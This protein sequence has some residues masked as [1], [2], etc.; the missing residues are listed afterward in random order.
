MNVAMKLFVKIILILIIAVNLAVYPNQACAA[1]YHYCLCCKNTICKHDI[2]CDGSDQSLGHIAK[3]GHCSFLQC[4]DCKQKENTQENV[5]LTDPST[6]SKKKIALA[7]CH[8]P[9]LN[10]T[11][12]LG[13]TTAISIFEQHLLSSFLRSECL[14]L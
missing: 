6:E 3:R 7:V 2:N 13:A 1:H 4:G 5:L 14:R 8:T 9:L 11:F 10:D 12:V